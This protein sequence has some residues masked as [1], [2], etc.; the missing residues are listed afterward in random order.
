MIAG[1]LALAIPSNTVRS[2]IRHASRRP[3]HGIAVLPVRLR[4]AGSERRALLV[5]D[6]REG[7]P[8][9]AASLLPGDLLTSAGERRLRAPEDLEEALDA[10]GTSVRLEFLRG[11]VR[12][13]RAVTVL[14]PGP[15]SLSEAA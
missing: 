13:A 4:G 3:R 10:A 8:A 12:R 5:T 14:L 2:F 9:A 6:V 1:G 11:D 15:A 7:S